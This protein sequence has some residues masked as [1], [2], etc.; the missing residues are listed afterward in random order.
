M[1]PCL[2]DIS[3][4]TFATN[5]IGKL[6]D[7]IS[8]IVT[9]KRN[10]SYELKME[11][12]TDGIHADELTEGNIILA[13]PSEGKSPQPFRIYKITTPLNGKLD[14]AARHISYQ[15]NFITVSPVSILSGT[16]NQVTLAFE[17]LVKNAASEC[18]FSFETDIA[19]SSY[20]GILEPTSFRNALGGIDGSMF[21]TFGGEFEWDMYTVKLLKNRGSDNGVRIVYGK[22]LV[23]FNMERSIKNVI[24]GVHPF[25]KDG[26]TGGVSELSEKVVTLDESDY[27]YE[28]IVVLDCS[29]QFEEQPTESALRS[30]AQSY[31]ESTSYTEPDID[32]DIDFAQLWQTAGYEDIAEAERVSL[33][34]TVHVYISKIGIEA[35][36]TVTETEYDTLLERYKSIT[37]SNSVTSSRNKSL[38]LSIATTSQVKSLIALTDSA[39][40]LSVHKTY[41][42]NENLSE[43]YPTTVDVKSLIEETE[44]AV[45]LSFTKTLESY[46]TTE[47][48]QSMIQLSEQ[49]IELSLSTTLQS[50]ST[51][52]QIQSMIQLSEQGIELSVTNTLNAYTKSDEIRSMFAMD[53]TSV[54]V[55]SGVITFESNSISIESDN[56]KLTTSGEVEAKGS[57]TSGE[58]DWYKIELGSGRITGYFENTEIRRITME[59][60]QLWELDGEEITYHG[61]EIKSEDILLEGTLV[62]INADYLNINYDERSYYYGGTGTITVVTGWE[63]ETNRFITDLDIDFNSKYATWTW[64]DISMISRLDY[65]TLRF[66]KGLMVTTL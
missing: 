58:D 6:A 14:I 39:I 35:D 60:D 25:W 41:V 5:G 54:S 40:R 16:E 32:I 27:P 28:K 20:F 31:L 52:E 19:S 57:F 38:S 15:L 10:G 55:S 53:P 29:E 50:Y 66:Q 22:N 34:D 21:D 1:I 26:E 13:K 48:I 63:W 7:C 44:N 46:S 4:A 9:E 23:D 49:G 37:L 24:T 8:C 62:D 56:F 3:E 2:Y 64:T 30:Y 12:P 51:T 47:Q 65:Q 17:G 33:C 61:I 11:Y 59:A 18:P 43:N 36:A 42:T 45:N